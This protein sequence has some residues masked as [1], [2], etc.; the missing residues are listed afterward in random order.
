VGAF[1]A[2]R[3]TTNKSLNWGGGLSEKKKRGSIGG[4]NIST[5]LCG[6]Q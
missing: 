6:Y 2:M 1:I 5:K 3:I 4:D